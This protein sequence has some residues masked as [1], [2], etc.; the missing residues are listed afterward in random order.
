MV[1]DPRLTMRNGNRHGPNKFAYAGALAAAR[2]NIM[3]GNY[4]YNIFNATRFGPTMI[5]SVSQLLLSSSV[6]FILTDDWV[7]PDRLQAG[8]GLKVNPVEVCASLWR[9]SL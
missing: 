9:S 6:C 5:E 2:V 8:A 3:C 7:G 1:E 4:Y